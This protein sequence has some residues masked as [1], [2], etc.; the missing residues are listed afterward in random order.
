MFTAVALA[1]ALLGPPDAGAPP[2]CAY[3]AGAATLPVTGHPFAAESSDDGCWLFVS[4]SGTA[5]RRGGVAVLHNEGGR[6]V[7]ARTVPLAED[8]TGLSLSHQGDRLLVASGDSVLVLDVGRLESGDPKPEMGRIREPSGSQPIY[9]ALSADDRLAFVSDER[10]ASITVIDLARAER[11]GFGRLAVV[12]RIAQG[13]APVGLALS[14]D[15]AWLYA[16]SQRA[17]A[18][19]RFP[20][21]CR[22]E[23]REDTLEHPEGFLSVI[24]VA[25]AAIDPAHA[26]RVA[27]PAGCNPVRVALASDGKTAWVTAR[28]ED[29]VY[30]I[31]LADPAAASGIS[32]RRFAVGSSPV[33][34]AV[35]PGS[36][37]VWVSDS[38]RFSTANGE[39]QTV[40]S[41]DAPAVRVPSGRFPRDLRFLP[42]GR[43]LVVAVFGSQAVQLVPAP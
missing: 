24:N 16:T 41:A 39:V 11:E 17:G 33:G 7:P 22:V 37:R 43:T 10:A 30:A 18:S 27:V 3:T 9:V 13:T 1:S 23:S 5:R 25:K 26:L 32:R 2:A 31:D 29:A 35:P 15:G 36:G 14:P 20:N 12:G 34:V 8:A 40:A 21:R 6:F 38:G 42:D 19:A 28:G 4:L